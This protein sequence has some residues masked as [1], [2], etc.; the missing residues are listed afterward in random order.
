MRLVPTAAPGNVPNGT[1][2]QGD[3]HTT[4]Q[5]RERDDERERRVQSHA[6]VFPLPARP[7]PAPHWRPLH[8]PQAVS[9]L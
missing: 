2:D 3:D 9:K 6:V 4:R 8:S 1:D 5:P 7:R